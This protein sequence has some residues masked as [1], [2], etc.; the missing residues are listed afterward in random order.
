MIKNTFFPRK[1]VIKINVC[2]EIYIIAEDNGH[3]L[4]LHVWQDNIILL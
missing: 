1:E 2:H 4:K 3:S